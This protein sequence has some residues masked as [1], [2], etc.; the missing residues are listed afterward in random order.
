MFSG[1][2]ADRFGRRSSL[3]GAGVL[4]F[5]SA[6]GCT[7]ADTFQSL[8]VFRIVGG[9]GFGLA[10]MVAPLYISEI[11]PAH[12]RG[13]MVA[14]YQFAITIGI[15]FAYFSNAFL[16]E[17]GLNHDFSGVLN[18]IVNDEVWRAM[19]GNETIPA[20]LFILILF[21]V[22]K[23]PRWLIM[24]KQEKKSMEILGLLLGV[25]AKEELANIRKSI[26]NTD[27]SSISEILRPWIRPVIIGGIAL[28]IL[29]QITGINAIIH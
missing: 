5:V 29:S 8:I 4:F 9:I 21:F 10:S 27:G 16:L 25:N 24:K 6:L 3:S 22:P 2:L 12:I 18:E 23:S 11:S 13:R 1:E 7:F 19:F 20:L 28:A 26:S 15:L 14:L 17:L